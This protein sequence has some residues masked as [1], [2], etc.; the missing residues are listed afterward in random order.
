MTWFKTLELGFADSGQL[1]DFKLIDNENKK[2]VTIT[3]EAQLAT[4][5]CLS[6]CGVLCPYSNWFLNLVPQRGQLRS[7]SSLTFRF[8][9]FLNPP[10]PRNS[11]NTKR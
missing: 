7:R 5:P 9:P 1:A 10:T 3:D 4:T 8:T 11:L 6:N 2:S